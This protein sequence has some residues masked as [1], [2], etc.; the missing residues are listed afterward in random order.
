MDVKVEFKQV[1]SYNG[2]VTCVCKFILLHKIVNY[3]F[4][5]QNDYK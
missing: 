1:N 4:L 2:D 5:F 3:I